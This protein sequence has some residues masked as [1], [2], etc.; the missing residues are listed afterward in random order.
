MFKIMK[1]GVSYHA[2]LKLTQNVSWLDVYVL[3]HNFLNVCNIWK[4]NI[5][6]ENLQVLLCHKKHMEKKHKV[7][8]WYFHRKIK[9]TRGLRAFFSPISKIHGCPSCR[10]PLSGASYRWLDKTYLCNEIINSRLISKKIWILTLSCDMMVMHGVWYVCLGHK[11]RSIGF[12]VVSH[13][14]C[15]VYNHRDGQN[16]KVWTQLATELDSHNDKF[17]QTLIEGVFWKKSIAPYQY[18]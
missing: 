3:T 13:T 6:I 2:V 16:P 7:S 12:W 17:W 4:L 10:V 5:Y 8:V 18:F 9:C 15:V 11:M 1:G 14:L